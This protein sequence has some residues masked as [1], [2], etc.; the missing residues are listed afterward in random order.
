[1]TINP[2]EGVTLKIGRPIQLRSKSLSDSEAAGILAKSF[3]YVR[4]RDRPKTAA[5]K[6]WVP[7]LCA[8]SGARGKKKDDDGVV[9]GGWPGTIKLTRAHYDVTYTPTGN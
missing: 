6:R 8:Y 2:A 5:A 9:A 1:M 4:G 7:W 3:A